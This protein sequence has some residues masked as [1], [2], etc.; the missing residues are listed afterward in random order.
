MVATLVNRYRVVSKLGDHPHRSSRKTIL[1]CGRFARAKRSRPA[2]CS[3]ARW[4]LPKA[5]LACKQAGSWSDSLAS[6]M[7]AISSMDGALWAISSSS[8][9]SGRTATSPL[10]SASATCS[11]GCSSSLSDDCTC[12]CSSSASFAGGSRICCRFSSSSSLSLAR[13]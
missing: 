7:L 2:P 8:A 11:L 13:S 9:P 3:L 10:L 5:S 4:C 6:F 1:A 12:S